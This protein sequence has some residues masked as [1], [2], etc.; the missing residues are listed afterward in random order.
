MQQ[1]GGR[2]I[3]GGNVDTK[4]PKK[5]AE[6]YVYPKTDEAFVA[7]GYGNRRVVG[8]RR[9]DRQIQADV[10]RLRENAV[11]SSEP[12]A[13]HSPIPPAPSPRV[14][15]PTSSASCTV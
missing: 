7:D 9:G 8:A 13:R 15:V 5:A 1:I 14:P 10:G 6:V 4:N 12:A 2:D 3:S 11:G